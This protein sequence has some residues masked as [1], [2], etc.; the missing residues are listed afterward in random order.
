MADKTLVTGSTKIS[1]TIVSTTL[2]V[3]VVNANL[4]PIRINTAL[5]DAPTT[6]DDQKILVYDLA[7]NVLEYTNLF[8]LMV[9]LLVPD[10]SDD[11]KV[12]TYDLGTDTFILSTSGQGDVIG[13]ASAVDDRIAVY[14]GTTGKLIKD[15]GVSI[16]AITASTGLLSGGALTI[17]TDTA[18]FDMAAM[19][20]L[21][22]DNHT[23]PENP[24]FTE[25]DLAAQDEVT[26]TNL[27]TQDRT[28]ISVNSSGTIVQRSSEGDASD[29]RDEILIGILIHPNNTSIVSTINRPVTRVDPDLSLIDLARVIGTINTNAGNIISPNGANLNIDKNIGQLF[30][31]GSNFSFL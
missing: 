21:I 16:S 25:I 6:G 8:D 9:A 31:I 4:D 14:D 5:V 15:S 12:L 13:P 20:G 28:F 30:R 11:G 17:G 19:K 27:A 18:K 24:T 3:D 26:V 2:E 22:V 29:I 7:G 23:D 10:T 1:L